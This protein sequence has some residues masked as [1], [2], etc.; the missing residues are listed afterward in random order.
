MCSAPSL[1][2]N[3]LMTTPT[4]SVQR[5]LNNIKTTH[6]QN[7]NAIVQKKKK[8][9]AETG[10]FL[11]NFTVPTIHAFLCRMRRCGVSSR[12]ATRTTGRCWLTRRASGS[13]TGTSPTCCPCTGPSS[14]WVSLT[15]L[16]VCRQRNS[17]LSLSHYEVHA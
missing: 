13:T 6:N 15:G 17:L 3:C 2:A 9:V 14:D 8:K 7:G 10:T 12:A 4:R 16:S 11:A 5:S 1:M